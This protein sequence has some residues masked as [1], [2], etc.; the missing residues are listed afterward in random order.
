MSG[1]HDGGDEGFIKNFMQTY[2]YNE[3]FDSEIGVSIESHVMAF[4]AEQSRINNGQS[5]DLSQFWEE[6][7]AN[8]NK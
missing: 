4:A 7:I 2:L 5:I 6:K 1:G 3:P 8:L